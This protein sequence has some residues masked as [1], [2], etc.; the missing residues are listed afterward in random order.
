[1]IRLA[2]DAVTGFSTAPLR[3]AL[4]AGLVM[5]VASVAYGLLAIALKL[6]GLPYVP[7][8]A[9]LLVTITFLSG[10][11]LTVIGMVG[12]YVARIYDEARGRPLYLVRE[13]RGFGG[14]GQGGEP[15]LWP[16][17]S[18]DTLARDERVPPLPPS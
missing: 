17:I 6:A 1:M 18:R 9:S 11:Q 7:G 4:A 3:F 15:S 8:Y 5:A 16:A 2:L 10:V 14:S 12:Q 13:A